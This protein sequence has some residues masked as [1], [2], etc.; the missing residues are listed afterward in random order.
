MRSY[1]NNGKK[2]GGEYGRKQDLFRCLRG[3]L[4]QKGQVSLEETLGIYKKKGI[5]M[6]PSANGP[7][8]CNRKKNHILGTHEGETQLSDEPQSKSN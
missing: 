6:P 8:A 4:Q 5:Q 2:A 1:P 3:N 7:E